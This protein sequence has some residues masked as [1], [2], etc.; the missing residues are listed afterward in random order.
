MKH[1]GATNPVAMREPYEPSCM[2]RRLCNGR[3][4]GGQQWTK[5]PVKQWQ[6][7]QSHDQKQPSILFFK[8]LFP[9]TLVGLRFLSLTEYLLGIGQS[10]TFYYVKGPIMWV[11]YVFFP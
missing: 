6:D 2:T 5:V 4:F 8:R 11:M 3:T 9:R 10:L 7:D 1:F